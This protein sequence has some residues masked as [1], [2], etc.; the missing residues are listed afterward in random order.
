MLDSAIRVQA[1]S[2]RAEALLGV[3]EEQAV[4]R[5]VGDLLVPAD[6]EAGAPRAAF[7]SSVAEAALSSDARAHVFVRP[8]NTFGVRMHARI[9]PCGP[10]RA[11]LLVLETHIGRLRPVDR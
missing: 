11:A 4:D 1:M 8:R 5:P 6:A 2:R 9:A 7:A 3:P 10:P